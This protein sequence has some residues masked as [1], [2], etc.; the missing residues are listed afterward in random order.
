MFEVEVHVGKN[1]LV[2]RIWGDV[3]KEEAQRVGDA[4]VSAIDR[5]RPRFDLLSDLKGVTSLDYEGTVHLRRIM[6]AAKARGFRRVVRVV[7]RSV[8][9]ALHFERTSREMGYDAYLAF[10]LEEAERLLDGG[11]P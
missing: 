3:D 5:M 8:E 11:G 7:G 1:R 9:A 10:S 6:E 2:V 4:A